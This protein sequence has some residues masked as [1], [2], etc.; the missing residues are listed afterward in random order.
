VADVTKLRVATY[1]VHHGRGT[2]GV[3]DLDRTAATI[4]QTGADLIALQE[5]DRNVR[6]SGGIDQPA[7]LQKLTGMWLRFFPTVPFEGGEFGL[8]VAARDPLDIKFRLLPRTRLDR[9][10]GMILLRTRGIGVVATHLS[11][12]WLGRSIE[13]ASLCWAC[14]R[15]DP[16]KLLLGDL[17][18]ARLGWGPMRL[19]GLHAERAFRPTF[20]SLH[21]RRQID[22]VLTSGDLRVI[23]SFTISSHASDH[24]PL[25]AEIEG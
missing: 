9:P 21:P 6:R 13:V 10:H 2:D 22:H 19:A 15:I 20:T 3:V 1:N 8:G 4:L 24:L 23:E 18:T 12:S 25:V 5:L 16:P 14:R 7:R 11:R 17:N